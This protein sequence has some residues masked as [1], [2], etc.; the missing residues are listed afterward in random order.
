MPTEPG[1]IGGG[2]FRQQDS[3]P[4]MPVVTIDVDDIDRTLAAIEAQG[5]STVEQEVRSGARRDWAHLRCGHDVIRSCQFAL[6]HPR[7][8]V[9]LWGRLQPA[10]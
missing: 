2:M 3:G 8:Y 5:G 10:G 1:Y 7:H 4:T 9:Y 6:S